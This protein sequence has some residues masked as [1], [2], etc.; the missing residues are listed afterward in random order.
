MRC[1]R[2]IHFL[3]RVRWLLICE[4]KAMMWNAKRSVGF[5]NGLDCARLRRGHR[6]A[7]L[8]QNTGFILICCVER[9]LLG[10]TMCGVLTSLIFA[11]RGY[12]QD[13]SVNAT[14]GLLD[15]SFIYNIFP[16]QNDIIPANRAD[17][18]QHG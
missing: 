3:G 7:S 17:M 6:Q 8:I 16:I 14:Q 18:R 2:N 4:L 15:Q 10:Q 1:T 5:M 12:Q 11:Y 13:S 9:R